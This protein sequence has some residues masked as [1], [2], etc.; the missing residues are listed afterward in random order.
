MINN[1]FEAYKIARELKRSGTNYEFYRRGL[2][3]FKEKSTNLKKVCEIKGLY[4]E[5]N[6][7]VQ[8]MIQDGAVTRTKKIPM[9]LCLTSND[10]NGLEIDDEIYINN[11]T[12]KVTGI[13]NIF[14]W[15]IVSDISL[16]VID[17]GRNPI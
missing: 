14:N 13:V 11:K 17:N 15:N 5:Q 10:V 4:H 1:K 2:N 16:E 7:N 9:I 6:S 12:Y 8:T 3:K